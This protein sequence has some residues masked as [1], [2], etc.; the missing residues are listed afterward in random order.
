MSSGGADI[1]IIGMSCIF[2][3]APNVQAY[4]QNIISKVDAIS[5]PPAGW[6]AEEIFDPESTANDRIYCKRGGYLRDLARFNPLDYGV[7]PRTVDGSEPEHFLA[8]RIAHEALADAGYSDRP[9]NREATA[10]ILGRGTFLNR[11]SV[12]SLQ[13]G[14][15]VDQTLEVLRQLHPEYSEEKLETIRQ[16]LKAGLPPFNAETAPGLVPNVMCGRIANRLDLRG[17]NYTVDAACA[18]SL[19]AV[20][21]AMR[22]LVTGRCDLALAG[23]VNVSTPPTVLMV[24]CQL[25]ALSRRGQI[26]PFDKDA[27]GVLLGEGLGMVVLKRRADAERDGDRIYALL[28][29][30]GISSD[31]RGLAVLAP[32]LEGEELALRRAYQVTGISPQTVELIEAH[33]TG[34]SVGDLTEVQALSRVFGPQNANGPWCAIG[35]VKSMIS[36]TIPAAG[37]ASLIKTALALHHKIL[38]PTINCAGP[39]PKFELERTP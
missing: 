3:G 31:G 32:R 18:S 11:G 4:W 17:P 35:S 14:L 27:D 20:D 15:I 2:P 34:T 37:I 36:H 5:D 16:E 12:T 33:G 39:N 6:G 26:R 23:G 28:K 1:A 24:F 8:L 10:V 9:F 19:V 38:P 29:G 7:M 30:V 13:H 22:E 25:G 21:L